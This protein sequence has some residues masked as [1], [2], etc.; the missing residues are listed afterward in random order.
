MACIGYILCPK[1]GK[2]DGALGA[3]IKVIVVQGTNK[4]IVKILIHP[5]SM[6]VFR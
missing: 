3:P 2:N 1:K 6:F 4:G 5:H